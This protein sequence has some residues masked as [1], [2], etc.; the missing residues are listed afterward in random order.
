MEI[1]NNLKNFTG[2]KNIWMIMIPK[3]MGCSINKCSITTSADG[4]RVNAEW[5]FRLLF[6]LE[7]KKTFTGCECYQKY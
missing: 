2:K 7:Q 5:N 6:A 3:R 4:L 1:K